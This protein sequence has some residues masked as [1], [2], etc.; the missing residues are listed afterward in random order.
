LCGSAIT[1]GAVIW[2]CCHIDLW[3]DPQGGIALFVIAWPIA[4]FSAVAFAFGLAL[5][6]P[7]A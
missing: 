6:R 4:L 3:H 1:F 7:R 2:L 5:R